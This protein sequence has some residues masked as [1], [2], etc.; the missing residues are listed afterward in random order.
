VEALGHRPLLVEGSTRNLKVTFPSDME[1]AER[2]L[3]EES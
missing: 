3:Q 1:I 2:L